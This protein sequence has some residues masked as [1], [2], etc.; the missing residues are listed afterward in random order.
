MGNN[1]TKLEGSDAQR[2]LEWNLQGKRKTVMASPNMETFLF[3]RAA[4]CQSVLGDCKEDDREQ[5]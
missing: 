2:A 1:L 3:G 4:G 5:K